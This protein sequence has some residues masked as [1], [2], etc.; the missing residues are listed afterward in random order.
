[1]TATPIDVSGVGLRLPPDLV[2]TAG[3]WSHLLS[4]G[5]SRGRVRPGPG[6]DR[7]LTTPGD[8]AP[9][10]LLA[11]IGDFDPAAFGISRAEAQ[12][13]DPQQRLLL[14]ATW[15]CLGDAGYSWT[16][17]RGQSVGVFVGA[18]AQDWLLTLAASGERLNAAAGSGASMSMLANRLSYLL[19]ITG[20]SMV[21][22]TACSSSLTAVHLAVQAIERG[23]CDRA[24]VAGVS[25]AHDP[26]FGALTRASLPLSPTDRCRPFDSEADGI[27]RGEGLVV[28]LLERAEV[29]R[30]GRH[31][32]IVGS[33]L[34]H[35][36]RTNGITAP[37]ATG[38]A[39][40]MRRALAGA[41][42][43]PRSVRYVEAH[44]TGTVLGDPI[45]AAA[46]RAV[47]A[48][49][50]RPCFVGS[51]KSTF[52]HLEAAAGLVGLLN[53]LLVAEHGIVPPQQGFAQENPAANLAASAMP[54]SPVASPILAEPGSY[55]TAVSSVGFGGSIVH[56]VLAPAAPP[57][58]TTAA[59]Q[60]EGAVLLLS[61]TTAE[62]LT[63]QRDAVRARAAALTAPQLAEVAA[64]QSRVAPALPRR[65]GWAGRDAHE[66]RDVVAGTAGG[67]AERRTYEGAGVVMVFSGQGASWPAMGR[68]LW[69]LPRLR[70]LVDRLEAEVHEV[71]GWSLSERLTGEVDLDTESAQI[72]TT[73]VQL[74]IVELLAVRGVRPAVVVG[75][76]MGEVTAAVVSGALSS[77]AA[78]AVLASR[79]RTIEAAARGGAMVSL[80]LDRPT[81]EELVAGSP[82]ELAVGAVNSPTTTV[83]SGTRAAVAAL[84]EAC[85]EQQVRAT[86]LPVDYAFHGPAL[87]GCTV[88]CEETASAPDV[89]WVS[90]VTGQEVQSPPEQ[91]YWS[92][93]VREPVN[94]VDAVTRAVGLT[95]ASV[96]VEVSP[97]PVL[98][99]DLGRTVH[100]SV[101]VVP[102]MLPQQAPAQWL[103]Q[104]VVELFRSGVPVDA[105][106]LVGWTPPPGPALPPAWQRSRYWPG[107]PAPAVPAGASPPRAGTAAG[108]GAGPG[109]TVGLTELAGF[110][111]QRVAA[112]LDD[113]NADRVPLDEPLAV[114]DLS[115]LAVVSIRNA[116][117]QRFG[118]VAPLPVLLRPDLSPLALAR[119]LGAVPDVESPAQLL[120]RVDELTDDEVTHLLQQLDTGS[121]T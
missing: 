21:V 28:L 67:D 9:E 51:V 105:A 17:L 72:C 113:V 34:G 23:E 25:L 4:S 75:H 84:A 68:D 90:T 63:A 104:V 71:A 73:A 36:G 106:A 102:T 64:R 8:G 86:L 60:G 108:A 39:D 11:S 77:R 44:G 116:V 1:M 16:A 43:S 99:G 7:S 20:P 61:A 5:S 114:W 118:L 31:G 38:Q 65:L 83:V 111:A 30:G 89:P 52:G 80:A 18:Y 6:G 85:T 81:V 35:G 95:G 24:V 29:S 70:P 76:S 66:L 27:V 2:D 79:A 93:N 3:V 87:R 33:A 54:V 96:V 92:A 109:V 91:Q 82:D 58:L 14:E 41:R 19:D 120:A 50:Q 59:P 56:V 98:L 94:L 46:L 53:A 47:Y 78:F 32:R 42:T 121:A 22:D 57:S 13:M 101:T 55:L 74:A 45:E 48:D 37:S 119:E 100:E 40:T 112:A 107:A 88:A 15:E 10:G 62:S 115:S 49:P 26:T 69:A 103:P 97:R 110:I 117:E 12:V